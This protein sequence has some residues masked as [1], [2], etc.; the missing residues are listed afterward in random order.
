MPNEDIKKL[1]LNLLGVNIEESDLR[2]FYFDKKFQ[3][4]VLKL[5]GK[6]NYNLFKKILEIISSKDL[7]HYKNLKF[8]LKNYKRV[9]VNNC[10]V[11]IFYDD[12]NKKVY[13]IDYDHHDKIYKN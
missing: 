5:N 8:N 7:T 3:K 4:K 6:E 13:F 1:F 9:H 12:I 11:I 10:Y 2:E